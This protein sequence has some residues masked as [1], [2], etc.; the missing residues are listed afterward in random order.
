MDVIVVRYS[1]GSNVCQREFVVDSMEEKIM[2][3]AFIAEKKR[4]GTFL[5]V[6]DQFIYI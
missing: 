5:E 6:L 3:E 1:I 2:C 4:E